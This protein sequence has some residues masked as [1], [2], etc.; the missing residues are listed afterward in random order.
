MELKEIIKR[1]KDL[2]WNPWDIEASAVNYEILD[3]EEIT[4]EE[5]SFLQE[6]INKG[7]FKKAVKEL[8]AE[9]ID[10]CMDIDIPEEVYEALDRALEDYTCVNLCVD[11]KAGVS[12]FWYDDVINDFLDKVGIDRGLLLIYS[13]VD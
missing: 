1:F 13:I 11:Y 9:E 3:S 4:R 7:E 10:G 8:W 12:D 2:G 6:A 5:L